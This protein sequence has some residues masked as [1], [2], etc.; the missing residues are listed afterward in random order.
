MLF[1]LPAGW[2]AGPGQAG[3]L[4]PTEGKPVV[5]R[6]GVAAQLLGGSARV[7]HSCAGRRSGARERLRGSVD[8]G[9]KESAGVADRAD[10]RCHDRCRKNRSAGNDH[11]RKRGLARIRQA[12]PRQARRFQD[13]D[14][15]ARR[16]DPYQD[17]S[18]GQGI[19]WFVDD[20]LSTVRPG[21]PGQPRRC[22]SRLRRAR[23]TARSSVRAG[24]R[25][26]RRW[27]YARGG[28]PGEHAQPCDEGPGERVWRL[29]LRPCPLIET[30]AAAT[31]VTSVDAGRRV[32]VL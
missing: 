11:S 26:V 1:R 2:E 21:W 27:V 6:R 24:Q 7:T 20:C 19:S 29:R 23:L 5:Q 28:R 13:A 17:Q 15:A 22:R 10:G 16:I 8:A 3:D 18:A 32:P 31:P 12:S 30:G 4:K 9:V 25:S 14:R